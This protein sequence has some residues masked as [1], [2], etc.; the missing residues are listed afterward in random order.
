MSQARSVALFAVSAWWGGRV[1][2]EERVRGRRER[3]FK[4]MR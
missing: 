4:V 2:V 3:T 1:M